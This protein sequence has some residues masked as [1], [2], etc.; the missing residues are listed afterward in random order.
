MLGRSMMSEICQKVANIH[1]ALYAFCRT[2]SVINGVRGNDGS[3]A[4]PYYAK[5]D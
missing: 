3:F 5:N 2:C 4:A 1:K